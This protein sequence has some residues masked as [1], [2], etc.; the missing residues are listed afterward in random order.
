MGVV[1]LVRCARPRQYLHEAG[2]TAGGRL[3]GVTEPRR[4]AAT[5][6]AQRVADEAGSLLGHTVG[7]S[8]RFDERFDPA[9]TRIKVRAGDE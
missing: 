2:W 8:I 6:L 3:V 5:S 1:R 9:T 7:Y 4:V